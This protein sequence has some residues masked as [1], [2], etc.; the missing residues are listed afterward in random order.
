MRSSNQ[1]TVHSKG[2]LSK[3]FVA[4]LSS[5][6]LKAHSEV[7]GDFG[8]VCPSGHKGDS[9]GFGELLTPVQFILPLWSLAVVKMCGDDL[10]A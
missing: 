6:L 4:R 2:P 3:E 9:K 5:G 1:A 7:S 8:H 10:K